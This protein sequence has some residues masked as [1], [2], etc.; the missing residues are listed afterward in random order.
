[1][2]PTAEHFR[3]KLLAWLEAADKFGRSYK[4]VNAGELHEAVG[5]YPDPNHRMPNCCSVMRAEMREG[6][7]IVQAPPQGDGASLTV[8]YELPRYHHAK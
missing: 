5:G 6:D 8:R 1:M 2:A 3:R 7:R 4:E